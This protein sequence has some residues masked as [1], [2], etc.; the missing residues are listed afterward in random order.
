LSSTAS[1]LVICL[2]EF[3]NVII[4]RKAWRLTEISMHCIRDNLTR[5]MCDGLNLNQREAAGAIHWVCLHLASGRNKTSPPSRYWHEAASMTMS[6]P[7]ESGLQTVL[8]WALTA[9]RDIRRQ[10]LEHLQMYVEV[11][12]T[13]TYAEPSS[14]ESACPI[15]IGSI[16]S[17]TSGEMRS[18]LTETNTS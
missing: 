13:I 10:S 5:S 12:Y 16:V 6:T 4:A 15:K 7:T 14:S 8:D 18:G 11:L 9:F 17:A 3:S 1:R 2:A